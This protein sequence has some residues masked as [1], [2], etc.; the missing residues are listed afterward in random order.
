ME[1]LIDAQHLSS[2]QNLFKRARFETGWTFDYEVN[3]VELIN[4]NGDVIAYDKK[5]KGKK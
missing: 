4:T 3:N 5:T 2:G 1:N